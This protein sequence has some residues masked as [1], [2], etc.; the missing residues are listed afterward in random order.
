MNHGGTACRPFNACHKLERLLVRR[1]RHSP[2]RFMQGVRRGSNMATQ[3]T[4][5]KRP[6]DHQEASRRRTGK[7]R[8]V[9]YVR[10]EIPNFAFLPPST[11][12]PLLRI[13][14]AT[15]TRTV[16]ERRLTVNSAANFKHRNSNPTV[17]Y[18]L[19]IGACSCLLFQYD[20]HCQFSF[21]DD[22]HNKP[23]R[24]SVITSYFVQSNL[25]VVF[26]KRYPPE[27]CGIS[28]AVCAR[29]R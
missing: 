28:K 9:L 18:S 5:V 10:K 16:K 8:T 19:S 25:H 26:A 6:T 3:T 24:A 13:C 17:R 22:P 20:S 1:A 15:G 7:I 27:C 23:R 12:E 11:Y 29:R 4:R 14:V 2:A 21:C